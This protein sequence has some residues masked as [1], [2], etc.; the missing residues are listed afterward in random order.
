MKQFAVYF[1][2]RVPLWKKAIYIKN[3]YPQKY[4]GKGI[5]NILL[6]HIIDY[7]KGSRYNYLESYPATNKTKSNE[8]YH[9]PLSSFLKNGFSIFKE[10]E[11]KDDFGDHK[12]YNIVRYFLCR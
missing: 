2:G 4:R 1:G 12:K 10:M 9:G 5:T 8:D 3:W 11:E 7:Y 6:K